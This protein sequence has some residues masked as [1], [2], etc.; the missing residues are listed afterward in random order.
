MSRGYPIRQNVWVSVNIF[1]KMDSNVIT[2]KDLD[3]K[4]KKKK[5]RTCADMG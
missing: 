5:R 1:N 3:T 2:A 4:N